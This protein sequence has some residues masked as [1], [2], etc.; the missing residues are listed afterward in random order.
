M[1]SATT[2]LTKPVIQTDRRTGSKVTIA[3]GV[4]LR[5][6]F[7]KTDTMKRTRPADLFANGTDWF[8]ESQKYSCSD[9]TLMAPGSSVLEISGPADYFYGVSHHIPHLTNDAAFVDLKRVVDGRLRRMIKA[10]NADLAVSLAEYRSSVNLFKSLSLDIVKAFRFMHPKQLLA[11]AANRMSTNEWRR[12]DLKYVADGWLKYQ[13]GIAP[14]VSDLFGTV[15][16]LAV[17]INEGFPVYNRA[18]A[19]DRQHDAGFRRDTAYPHAYVTFCTRSVRAQS[20]HLVTDASLKRLSQ[21]GMTNPAVV[22]WELIPYSFVID[23]VLGIGRY[24]ES[25]DALAGVDAIRVNYGYLLRTTTT[26]GPN[27]EIKHQEIYKKRFA[28]Q[29]LS[30]PRPT[31]R[32]FRT[33]EFKSWGIPVLN[34]LA[35]LAQI[36]KRS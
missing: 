33:T 35:V 1:P 6:K 14:L 18:S 34:D 7:T 17:R 9:V 4:F 28:S 8:F 22:A 32:T 19:V 10:K 29:S 11:L 31:F 21:L 30:M 24:L 23:Q 27:A 15:E 12:G 5:D 20:R 2:T 26:K 36:A 13:F 16:N 3:S 25:L